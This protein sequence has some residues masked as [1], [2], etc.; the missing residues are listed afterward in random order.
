MSLVG[1]RPGLVNQTELTAARERH[2]IFNVRPS[3]TGFSQVNAIDMSPRSYSPKPMRNF[4]GS[5][6]FQSF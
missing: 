4:R 2:A 5:S 3:I 1:P 6:R